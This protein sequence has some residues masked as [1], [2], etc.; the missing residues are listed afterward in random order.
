MTFPRSTFYSMEIKLYILV[1]KS[2]NMGDKTNNFR[3]VFM[4]VI[5]L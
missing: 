2:V 3:I 1:I 4:N 5:I